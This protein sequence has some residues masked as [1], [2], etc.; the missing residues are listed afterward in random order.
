M[1]IYILLTIIMLLVG[2]EKP[3]SDPMPEPDDN[4]IENPSEE[5]EFTLDETATFGNIHEI[6]SNTTA[7]TISF[8]VDVNWELRFASYNNESTD[9]ATADKMSGEPGKHTVKIYFEPNTTM[10]NRLLRVEVCDATQRSITRNTNNEM[11]N[12]INSFQ[13]VCYVI[14]ILQS[15][16]YSI[17]YPRGLRVVVE[18]KHG[19]LKGIIDAH[20]AENNLTYDDI[21]YLEIR[22]NL[23]ND[24]QIESNYHF[25]NDYLLNLKVLNLR[26]AEMTTIPQAAFYRNRSIH[27]ITLPKYLKRIGDSAFQDSELRDVNIYLPPSVEHVGWNAFAGT[28]ISGSVIIS[29]RSGYIY[30]GPA[31]FDSP[32]IFTA[33]FC[34]GVEVIDGGSPFNVYLSALVLP[35]SLET[36]NYSILHNTLIVC[37]Y[38]PIPPNISDTMLLHKELVGDVLVPSGSYLLYMEETCPWSSL[39]IVPSLP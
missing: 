12:M 37:C 26:Y 8:E 32:A 13:G 28:Q 1:R 24:V 2:C 23:G 20:I 35:S 14:S 11:G 34:E 38:A 10:D 5:P 36:I 7:A 30:L 33:V 9:W 22:G 29:S 4:T 17:E 18:P 25:I 19:S 21:E 39:G 3:S 27:Y 15:A 6:E 31:S 16:Y